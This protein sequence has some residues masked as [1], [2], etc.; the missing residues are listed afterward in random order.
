MAVVQSNYSERQGTAVLGG[1]ATSDAH[2]II[3]R[4]VEN[5]DGIGFGQVACQGAGDNGVVPASEA[6]GTPV[7]RG[8]T[9]RDQAQPPE[10]EDTYR[11]Y[12][13]ARVMLKGTV[14][15]TAGANVSA[16]DPVYFVPATGV[17]TNVATDNIAIPRAI[18]DQ[19][20]QSG[21]LVRLR[22]Q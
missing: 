11:R 10:A 21:N 15:V 22:L 19:S 5:A 1:I 6:S 12:D 7:Y 3:A 2:D 9:L 17:I 4:T 18:F 20:A 16:G 14:W 8:I 13:S